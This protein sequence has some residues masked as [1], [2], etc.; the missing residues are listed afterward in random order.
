MRT[1]LHIPEIKQYIA[2]KEIIGRG[3]TSICV[4][5]SGK[6]VMYTKDGIKKDYLTHYL[7]LATDWQYLGESFSA[8]YFGSLY[9]IDLPILSPIRLRKYNEIYESLE[10]F[11]RQVT[12]IRS[13]AA[14]LNFKQRDK[15]RDKLRNFVSKK[16]NRYLEPLFMM[17][18]DYLYPKHFILDLHSKNVM[19]DAKG[20]VVVTDPII[21]SELLQAT[22]AL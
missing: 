12:S 19:I 14:S 7:K 18:E 1:L 5:D 10:T 3:V 4:E 11:T 22:H 2:G 20:S 15:S 13:F 17:L 21:E 16:S 9:R 8:N 6:C